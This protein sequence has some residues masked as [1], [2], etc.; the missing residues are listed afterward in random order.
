MKTSVTLP[1]VPVTVLE[2]ALDFV[3]GKAN[4]LLLQH[5]ASVMLRSRP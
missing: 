2:S 3:Q 4:Q 1:A 5:V